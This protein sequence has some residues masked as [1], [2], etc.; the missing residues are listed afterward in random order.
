MQSITDYLNRIHYGDCIEVMRRMPAASVDLCLTD[1]PYLVRY[2]SRDGRTIA[3]DRDA[4]W[5]RPA[6]R[7]I[8]RVL[9]P[10]R[11]CI[12]FYG[13]QDVE[14]FMAAWKDAGLRPVGHFV[15]A[16]DYPS[17]RGYTRACHEQAYL[18][19]KG[20]PTAPEQPVWDVLPWYYR[21]HPTEKHPLS[22][23]PLIL[24]YS[25]VGD[26]VLDPFAG[27]GS[28]AEAAYTAHR[29]YIG[30]EKVGTYCRSAR[31]RLAHVQEGSTL[32]V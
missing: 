10:D 21:R 25:G 3:G 27:S 32:E 6:F 5:L 29:N 14:K 2:R 30:I 1:P 22:L 8:A 31:E 28:T 23:A 7:E 15:W 13:W 9:K 11:F 26:I 17:R 18:L 19:A 12:S 16:K 4:L 20:T 24:A